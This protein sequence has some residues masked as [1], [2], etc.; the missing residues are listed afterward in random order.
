MLYQKYHKIRITWTIT[1]DF[2]PFGFR[3]VRITIA[4]FT[5]KWLMVGLSGGGSGGGNGK[6][7]DDNARK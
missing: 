4:D 6:S 5:N 7:S 2:N 3:I 1:S